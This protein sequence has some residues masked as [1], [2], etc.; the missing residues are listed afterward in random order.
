[1]GAVA[2]WL[3]SADGRAHLAAAV[4]AALDG[5]GAP[6]RPG[7]APGVLRER[8]AAGEPLTEDTDWLA[9]LGP[10]RDTTMVRGTLGELLAARFVDG[11]FGVD[12]VVAALV[13]AALV[14]LEGEI[15]D[16]LDPADA[17]ARCGH[18]LAAAVAALGDHGLDEWVQGY[19]RV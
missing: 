1:V 3:D 17:R 2:A 19:G 6:T 14:A 15:S 13:P 11:R 10:F 4:V 8:R 9:P 18:A 7:G 12:V 5:V 16:A